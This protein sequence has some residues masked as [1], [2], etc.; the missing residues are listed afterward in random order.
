MW[1]SDL[2]DKI[3]C[4]LFFQAE[5][6]S[7]VLYGCTAWTLTKRMEKKVDDHYT[8]MLQAILKGSPRKAAA[9]RITTT[10][11]ENYQLDEPDMRDT[12]GAVGTNS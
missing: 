7:I 1:K 9:A 3:K 8:I 11:H 5:V 10:H 6:V 4:S 2:T 12:A